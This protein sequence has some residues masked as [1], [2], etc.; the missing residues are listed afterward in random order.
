MAEITITF[1]NDINTSVQVGDTAY[2]CP[3]VNSG[4]FSTAEQTDIVEIGLITE[5]EY[6]SSYIKCNSLGSASP[7]ADDF[8]LFSKDNAVN[9]SSPTG[10]YAKVKF[11]NNSLIK[12][13]MF[14]AS[15]DV[16]ESS[17]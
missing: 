13:E 2:Y 16:F 17:K 4:G 1:A 12:S 5:V 9:M 11:V 3:T 8:I 7:S 10:Y 6:Q 15:C 14:A